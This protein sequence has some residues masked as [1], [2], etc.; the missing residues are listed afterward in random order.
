MKKHVIITGS[1][2]GIGRE[3][4]LLL[5]ENNFQVYGYAR[6]N[7]IKHKHFMFTQVDLSKVGLLDNLV[8]PKINREDKIYLINNA[9]EIGVIN[10]IG[11][12]LTNEIID[13]INI[14][15]IAPTILCNNVIKTYKNKVKELNILNISSGAALRPIPS[16]GTYCQSKAALDML[17]NMIK[18]E[19]DEINALSIS[20]GIV[21]TDMQRKI[22]S[23]SSSNF[24]LKD[25]FIE[26]YT[27]GE[28]ADPLIIARK[29][30]YIMANLSQFK[31]N[32]VSLRDL[33]IK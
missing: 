11:N 13:E 14:N 2:K 31:G 29:I 33:S 9:G 24:P 16:W 10:P 4:T 20:P 23:V 7:S 1:S 5:L 15:A 8:F 19:N 25:K 32:I 30:F 26:Y 27:N 28:L 18:E 6:T 21:D 3:L 17:T 12:K 22:R